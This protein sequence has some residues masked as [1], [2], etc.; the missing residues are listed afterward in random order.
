MICGESIRVVHPLFQ[1]EGGGSTPTSPLQLHMGWMSVAEAIRLNALWHSRVPAFTNPPEKC[2]AIGAEHDGIYYAVSVAG[3][4]RGD[5]ETAKL[6][7]PGPV[8]PARDG[9][10]PDRQRDAD[11]RRQG[12]VGVPALKTRRHRVSPNRVSP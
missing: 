12:A 9:I 11:E 8:Q 10:G 6:V 3:R 7:A 4:I 1:T 2:K 5:G